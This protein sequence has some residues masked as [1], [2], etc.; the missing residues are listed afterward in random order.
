MALSRPSWRNSHPSNETYSL[1]KEELGNTSS[2]PRA[3][4]LVY[5]FLAL[6]FVACILLSVHC[7][8][9]KF[10]VVA[11]LE[12]LPLSQALI[13]KVLKFGSSTYS[14]PL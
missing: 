9:G 8:I 2:S 3:S 7:H 11:Y 12:N 13:E 6:Y 10:T 1:N 4:T 5:S 14:P